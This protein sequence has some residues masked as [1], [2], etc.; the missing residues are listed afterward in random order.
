MSP[1]LI[2]APRLLNG[3]AGVEKKK[4]ERKVTR[5]AADKSVTDGVYL[6]LLPVFFFKLIAGEFNIFIRGR[7]RYSHRINSRTGESEI[8]LHK[9]PRHSSFAGDASFMDDS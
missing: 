5:H 3:D 9:F 4:T 7:G 8:Y 6:S 2:E 1:A